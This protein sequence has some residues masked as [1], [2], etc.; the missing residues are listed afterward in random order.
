MAKKIS[1]EEIAKEFSVS[2]SYLFRMFKEKLNLS[3]SEYILD[4]RLTNACLLLKNPL[5]T[6][7]QVMT[8]SGFSD[9]SNFL[10]LFKRKY[11][12]TPRDYRKDPFETTKR[13]ELQQI[14]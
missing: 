14:T 4:I 11:G 6:N 7:Y 13:I 1:I 9:Y 8:L 2:R 10:K 12:V 3:V 5:L